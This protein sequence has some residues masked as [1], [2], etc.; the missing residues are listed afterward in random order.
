MN[1]IEKYKAMNN[2]DKLKLLSDMYNSSKDKAQRTIIL[3]E[4]ASIYKLLKGLRI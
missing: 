1:C 3:N 2:S 4:A